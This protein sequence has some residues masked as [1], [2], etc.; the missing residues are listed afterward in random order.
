MLT[1]AEK[2]GSGKRTQCPDEPELSDASFLAHLTTPG[3]GGRRERDWGR[4]GG[5][6]G[7]PETSAH[8]GRK[9]KQVVILENNLAVLMK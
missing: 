9:H 8:Q 5:G 2:G 7:E 3:A 6:R 4:G 1:A